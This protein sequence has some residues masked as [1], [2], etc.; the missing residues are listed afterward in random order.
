MVFMNCSWWYRGRPDYRATAA[1]KSTGDRSGYQLTY[2][3]IPAASGLGNGH[4]REEYFEL[5]A[6]YSV[7]IVH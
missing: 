2:T 6:I 4:L 7:S 5:Q 1:C 3:G